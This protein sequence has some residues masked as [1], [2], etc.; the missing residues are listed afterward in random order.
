MVEDPG[1]GELAV[2]IFFSRKIR[3]PFPGQRTYAL[4]DLEFHYHMFRKLFIL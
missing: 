4:V 3:F 2:T 1:T